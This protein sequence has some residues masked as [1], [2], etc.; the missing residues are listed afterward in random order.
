M[1]EENDGQAPR[2]QLTRPKTEPELREWL[3]KHLELRLPKAAVCQ[4]HQSPLEYLEC[5]FFQKAPD[6]I[7][8]APRGGGKTRLG[9]A[10][11]LL[12]LLFKAPCQV[13]ILGG[14]LE[15]SS[16]MWEYLGPDVHRLVEAEV[17]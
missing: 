1:G 10:A 17:H 12:D 4:H 2:E 8:W 9:A 3:E 14:S 11:T 5:A 13:R 16:R 6:I 7:V 15:Q